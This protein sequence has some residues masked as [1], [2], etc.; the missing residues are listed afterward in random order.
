MSEEAT[1]NPDGTQS[2]P[3]PPPTA[4]DEEIPFTMGEETM[5]QIVSKGIDP[6][7]YL[8]IA[9]VLVAAV[10]IYINY[11]NKNKNN[12]DDFFTALDGD[13]FNL[14]LPDEV[15]EYYTIKDKCI[16]AGWVPGQTLPPGQQPAP[17]GPHRV[18]AQALM[19][20]CIADIP[21]VTHIQKEST[22]MNKLYAQSMCSVNQWRSYQM[23]ESLVSAEVDEV[24]AEAD[25]IEP[26]WSQ[27]IWRQAM[28]YH[29]ML[30]E[31]HETEAKN[32]A[33]AARKKRE[34][35]SKVNVQ[36]QEVD[37][38]KAKELAAEKAAQELL[39][40][41]ERQAATKKAF[42]GGDGSSGLKKGFLNASSGKKK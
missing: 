19:K 16:A 42:K 26:G 6:A 7:I 17:N 13:K 21:I 9:A 23:A 3:Q 10:M 15:N 20:R 12:G 31:K 33:E 18:M 1:I 2:M 39:K 36:Q 30:K 4:D 34:I 14:K 32:A 40:M 22:G 27:V 29:Q 8:L 41:E 25:E 37:D 5:Q 28:Q 24:R 38:V 35:E 11:K